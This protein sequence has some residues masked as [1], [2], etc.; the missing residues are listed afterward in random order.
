MRDVND[1]READGLYFF[2][3]VDKWLFKILSHAPLYLG[4]LSPFAFGLFHPS[5]RIRQLS[6]EFIRRIESHPAGQKFFQ[7]LN[8]FH[9]LAYQRQ[10]HYLYKTQNRLSTRVHGMM[11][12]FDGLSSFSDQSFEK[13]F[14]EDG[15]DQDEFGMMEDWDGCNVMYVW[16]RLSWLRSE[17]K[18]RKYSIMKGL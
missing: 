2:F 7:G 8:A 18:K 14:D 4:G 1:V 3:W 9:R 10:A 11:D 16:W 17:R 6:V 12:G 13:P 15:G 5:E